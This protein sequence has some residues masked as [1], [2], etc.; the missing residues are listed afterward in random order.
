[1]PMA[2]VEFKDLVYTAVFAID[3]G[4]NVRFLDGF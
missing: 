4:L 1:M 3:G 2:V